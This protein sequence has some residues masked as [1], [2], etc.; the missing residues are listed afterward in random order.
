MS[1]KKILTDLASEMGVVVT[2]D[3]Q[4][5]YWTSRVNDAAEELYSS[6][7][8]PGCLM[9]NTFNIED[10]GQTASMLTLPWYV[11]ELRGLR[12]TTVQGGKIPINDMRPRYH[13]GRGWGDNAFSIPFRIVRENVTLAREIANAAPLTFTLP[14]AESADVVITIIGETDVAA[15]VQE[16]VTIPAG[17]LQITTANSWADVPENIE[18]AA[19]NAGD[20]VIT[21]VEDNTLGLIPNSE[22]TPSYKWVEITDPNLGVGNAYGSTAAVDILFKKPFRRFR[23]VYDEFPCKKCDRAIFYKVAEY[24]EHTD[25]NNETRAVLFNRKCKQILDD[26][27]NNIDMARDLELNFGTNGYAEAMHPDLMYY[28]RRERL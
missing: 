1:L 15:R 19:L 26:L 14:K 20:I 10:E 12:F 25:R 3:E 8:I 6:T 17:Q 9:E 2:S 22:L 21:D 7:D 24:I 11:G 27:I 23:N 13:Y 16:T 4:L 5:A 18:K 28:G